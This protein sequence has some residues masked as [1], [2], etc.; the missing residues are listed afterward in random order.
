[1]HALEQLLPIAAVVKIPGFAT[2]SMVILCIGMLLAMY[3][4]IKGPSMPDR[5]VALDCIAIIA[6]SI[7]VLYAIKTGESLFLDV[8]IA[9][10]LVLFLGTVAFARSFEKRM[11]E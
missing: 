5:I 6:I 9:M 3:R 2:V 8:A 4:M 10:A 7:M 11:T 1:M